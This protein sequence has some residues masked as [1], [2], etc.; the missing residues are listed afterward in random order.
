MVMKNFIFSLFLSNLVVAAPLVYSRLQDGSQTPHTSSITRCSFIP[1]A[2]YFASISSKKIAFYH[3]SDEKF[4]L[5]A[6]V[7]TPDGNTQIR[8]VP[9]QLLYIVTNKNQEEMIFY[10]KEG[11]FKNRVSFKEGFKGI[12]IDIFG[13][14]NNLLSLSEDSPNL[15]SRLEIWDTTTILHTKIPIKQIQENQIFKK[16]RALQDGIHIALV[17]PSQTEIEIRDTS[18]NT[19]FVTLYTH[20][21]SDTI[22]D[23]VTTSGVHLTILTQTFVRIYNWSTNTQI[24]Q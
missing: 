13:T 20:V 5:E 19:N 15:N 9:I 18:L 6:K 12:D 24:N 3:I 10:S 4:T 2:F 14:N 23:F 7:D 17:K 8:G 22:T 1:D 16:A 21:T 11:I